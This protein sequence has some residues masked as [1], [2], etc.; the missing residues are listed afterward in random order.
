MPMENTDLQSNLA[1]MED[2]EFE[3]KVDIDD[4]VLPSKPMELAEIEINDII[5]QEPVEE[6]EQHAAFEL[7]HDVG[8]KS[9]VKMEENILKLCKEL[10]KEKSENSAMDFKLIRSLMI[11]QFVENIA[12]NDPM[13]RN[14]EVKPFSCKL[15]DKSFLQVYE[16][17][18]HIKIHNSISEVEDLKNQVKSL[19]IQVEELRLKL[20][21]SQSKT[22][23]RQKNRFKQ[24][25]EMERKQEIAEQ[26]IGQEGLKDILK[27]RKYLNQ[28]KENNKNEKEKR[29]D[30]DHPSTKR[31]KEEKTKVPNPKYFCTICQH[32]SG[33]SSNFS[34]HNKN[35]HG[36]GEK[37]YECN[38]CHHKF[39]T[40]HYLNKHINRSH[41][42][43]VF[44]CP[45]C[46]VELKT[47]PGLKKHLKNHDRE[48]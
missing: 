26:E 33:C 32:Q 16:V 40:K 28:L 19:K 4:L 23:T 48:M 38:D 17:K 34:K 39:T 2:I 27:Q 14:Y 1:M 5:K 25:S 8:K 7:D 18:E 37:N 13:E 3:E 21:S 30:I 43:R 24:R 10:D 15:C 22:Q 44:K 45:K 12:Q 42:G 31:P 9:K 36:T 6:K 35:I 11:K 47:A 41:R 29:K 20:D 46:N